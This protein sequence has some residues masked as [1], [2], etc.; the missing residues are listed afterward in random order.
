ERFSMP[1]SSTGAEAG[2]E[3]PGGRG[4]SDGAGTGE[5]TDEVAVAPAATLATAPGP[6]GRAEISGSI[7][8]RRRAAPAATARALLERAQIAWRAG[9]MNEAAADYAEVLDRH[10]ADPRAALA[11]F[12]LGRIQMDHLADLTGATASFERAL[13]LGPRASFQEDTLARLAQASDRL[14]RGADCRRA[15]Q[16]YLREYPNGL[17]VTRVSELCP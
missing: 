11:A 4:D 10:P 6:A 17:H 9:R 2:G 15:R 12:E 16:R 1:A 8:G 14:G 7:V 5:P 3:T 13:H